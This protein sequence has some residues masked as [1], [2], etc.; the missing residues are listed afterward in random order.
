MKMEKRKKGLG[1]KGMGQFLSDM[2]MPNITAFIGW[3]LLT[4]LFIPTGWL[5][6]E[7]MAELVDPMIHY[8][9]PLLIGY[10]AGKLVYDSRGGVIGAMATLGVVVGADIPMFL[11]AMVMGPIGGW[12]IRLFD[13]MVK[14]RV[15][16][17][18]EILVSNF[19]GGIIGALLSVL[20]LVVIG[21]AVSAFNGLLSTG[22]EFIIA[23]D[24]LGI[25][26]LIIEPAKVLFLNNVIDHGI[27]SPL[28]IA[29]AAE[30]GK[31]ILFLLVVNPG[32]GL[33]LL[34]SYYCYGKGVMKH[35]AS[36]AI[37]I[38][39][40]GGIHEI[41]Y[42]FVLMNPLTLIGMVAGG[43]T[44]TM[45]FSLLDAGLVATASPGSIFSILAMTPKNSMVGVIAGVASS[46]IVSFLVCSIFV[47]KHN[48]SQSDM[49]HAQ[50]MMRNVEAQIQ[51]DT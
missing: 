5:P 21:P 49:E 11:G 18:M 30:V 22:M 34:V 10:T 7:K 31:S 20:G 48:A 25:S 6:N 50:S 35:S 15:P 12:S 26:A 42:P 46:A 36:G 29:Q 19:S 2:V 47:K 17:S 45:V 38:H 3:G 33:G 9:L 23:H 8:L 24:A 41:Y 27:L 32:P 28:G 43:F 51:G 39:F 16:L 13:R 4:A 37:I 40:L 1:I 14:G 44:G